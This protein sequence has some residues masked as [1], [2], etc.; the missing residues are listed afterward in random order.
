MRQLT[1]DAAQDWDPGF[2]P[3]GQHI[4]WSCDRA[5]HLEIWMANADG[6]GP[7][8]V[9]QD[10]LDAENPFVSRDGAW[11][12]YWSGN[13]SKLGIWKIHPDGT[14]AVHLITG[15]FLQPEVSPDGR[16]VLY[17]EID[18]VNQT[19]TLHLADAES[20]R[21]RAFKIVV[22]YQL[23]GPVVNFG[24][25]R[26]T[27]DGRFVFYVGQ[28]AAG[29]S[30]VFSQAFDPDGDTSGTRRP[31][32]G[33]S[34]EYWTESFGVSPDGSRLTISTLRETSSIMLAEGVPG[35]EPPRRKGTGQ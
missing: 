16:Y 24:R 1:D 19:S 33:F 22:P 27:P 20:G 25:S 26:W 9:S 34:E 13:P 8:Q 10:G 30:G 29:R 11:I 12:Y 7:R 2:A 35:A 23:G 18:R 15:R 32:A 17:I 5:G 14:G 28:D 4:V 3:D 31:V 21:T 6:S